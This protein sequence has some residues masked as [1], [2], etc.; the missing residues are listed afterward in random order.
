MS[1]AWKK[2]SLDEARAS[3]GSL[4]NVKSSKGSS[5]D[6]DDE[7]TLLKKKTHTYQSHL[8]LWIVSLE[9]PPVN[10][11]DF[12]AAGA[13]KHSGNEV[14]GATGSLSSSK[15]DKK[16]QKNLRQKENMEKKVREDYLKKLMS[17]RKDE[18]MLKEEDSEEGESK[19][20][21][22]LTV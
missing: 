1:K 18:L 2:R 16:Q 9:A 13:T 10:N 11:V 5:K 19:V 20:P 8:K 7:E 17:F 6:F 14:T 12:R 15:A 3:G 21:D 22:L 4:S